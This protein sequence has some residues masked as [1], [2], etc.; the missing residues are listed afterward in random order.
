MKQDPYEDNLGLPMVLRKYSVAHYLWIR[1]FLHC[2]SWNWN[3]GR[4]LQFKSRI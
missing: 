2:G 3:M 1:N 4:T